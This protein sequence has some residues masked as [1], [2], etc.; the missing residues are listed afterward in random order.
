VGVWLSV[1]R[2]IFVCMSL[3][4]FLPKQNDQNAAF[5]TKYELPFIFGTTAFHL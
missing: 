3:R 4:L 1:V 5:I 2:I